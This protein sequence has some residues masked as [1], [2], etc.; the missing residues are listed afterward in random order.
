MKIIDMQTSVEEKRGELTELVKMY[1]L[2]HEKVV[3]CSKE[4]DELVYR[5]MGSVT[6]QESMHS[7]SVRKNMNDNI[8]SP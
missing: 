6:Y 5:L 4:L 3:V 1:G 8:N 7:I 2:N